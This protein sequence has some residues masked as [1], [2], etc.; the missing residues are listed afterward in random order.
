M[1]FQLPG[2][3]TPPDEGD[4]E[5]F[6]A[7]KAI[8]AAY[9][10]LAKIPGIL[11]LIIQGIK[12]D[13][14]DGVILQNIRDS[15]EYK[16][17]FAGMAIREKAGFNAISEYE[18][19]ELE[20]AYRTL[21][22]DYGVID[23]LAPTEAAFDSLATDWI[24]GDVSAVELSERLDS[25]YAAVRDASAGVKEAF[26]DFYGIEISDETLLSYFLDEDLGIKEMEK[27]VASA[28][29]G[30]AAYKY[31]LNITRTR[32][33]LLRGE[34]VSA[35]MA[36]SGFADITREAPQLE[37]LARMHHYNPLSQY[38]LEELVFHE[39]PTVASARRRIFDSA[40]ADFEGA[41]ATSITRQGTLGELV[42]MDRTV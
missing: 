13:L 12:D 26:S 30:G 21:L 4:D 14:P 16:V 5:I 42:D 32:A 25:G 15:D 34:G 2:I 33:E 35:N 27:Q 17:R 31:G 39:D 1:T 24:G 3:V 23:I 41:G 18:Y 8:E 11:N 36:H 22:I 6:N 37:K 7:A 19:L 9:P 38:D 40:L 10:W 20:D 28:T 29:I